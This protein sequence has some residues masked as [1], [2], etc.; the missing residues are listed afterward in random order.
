L[1]NRVAHKDD[2]TQTNLTNLID[3]LDNRAPT[4][5]QMPPGK[6]LEQIY[7]LCVLLSRELQI[8][9][10][11][12]SI[13]GGELIKKDFGSQEVSYIFIPILFSDGKF[14]ELYHKDFDDAR[15]FLTGSV[16]KHRAGTFPFRARV[17]ENVDG[18]L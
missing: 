3:Q 12:F 11:L 9:I 10:R 2:A 5:E 17:F 18:I 14:S 13:S 6:L 8:Y 4:G 7:D 16:E 1:K 15:K